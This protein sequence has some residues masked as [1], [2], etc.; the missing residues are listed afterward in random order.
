M[1]WIQLVTPT[2]DIDCR[3]GWCLE[4]VRKTF[5][6]PAR[7][8]T[9]TEAWEGSTSQHRDQDFPDAWVPVWFAL[10]G[11]PAGHVALRAPDGS[12]YSTT[13]PYALTPVHHPNLGD[14]MGRYARVGLPLTYLG[15]T[16]DIAGTP[17]TEKEDTMAKLDNDDRKF[18]QELI[19]GA[20]RQVWGT[21]EVTQKMIQG[22]D[23][24]LP[25]SVDVEDIVKQ[26]NDD[27]A[28]RMAS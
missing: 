10:A 19:N 23:A 9:A 24:P 11:V 16:E 20:I 25:G 13:D 14:L 4:Y 8:D 26:I 21:A 15:W 6:Q 28:R 27:A 5:G 12:V 1:A 7:Y 22:Q 17:V 2:P 3:P 18:I